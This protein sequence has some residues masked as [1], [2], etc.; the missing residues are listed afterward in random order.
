[1]TV[2]R[3]K[4]Q[5]SVA[6]QQEGALL[7]KNGKAGNSRKEKTDIRLGKAAKNTAK[8]TEKTRFIVI[9]EYAGTRSRREA[10]EEA[11]EHCILR[12][13]EERRGKAGDAA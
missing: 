8:N 7:K 3:K 13:I 11:I 10:F 5:S 6:G 4:E 9:R 1:M 2:K 12:E